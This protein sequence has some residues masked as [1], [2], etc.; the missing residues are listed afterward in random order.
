MNSRREQRV[1]LS[2]PY[3]TGTE[4]QRVAAAIESNWLAPLGPALA[5][6][7]RD[8]AKITGFQHVTAVSSGTA[9]LHLLLTALDLKP[10][11]DIW[12]P[13][14]TFMGGVSPI[15]FCGHRPVFFDVD[16]AN[17]TLSPALIADELD[18]S[19]KSGSLPRAIIA[20]DLFGHPFDIDRIVA[21]A[22]RYNVPVVGDSAE[23]LGVLCRGRHAG[24]GTRGAILSFNGNKIITTSGG[25]AVMTDDPALDSR[26]RYFATQTREPVAWYEHKEVGFN[27][28]L[29]NISAALGSAQLESLDYRVARRRDIFETYRA[30]LSDIDG[31]EWTQEAD[32]AFHTRWLSV[33]LVPESLGWKAVC[34][35]VESLEKLNIEARP[36]WKPMHLQPVFKTARTVGGDFSAALFSR[37]LCLPSGTGMTREEQDAVIEAVRASLK[38]LSA[39]KTA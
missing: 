10:D 30:R 19:A 11:G 38:A 29:S 25:G 1:F 27:Y 16:P 34:G 15:L 3:Q 26:I 24:R 23:G 32:W 6:F 4:R 18:R 31:V 22:D 14:L 33:M 39:H 36:V 37:G 5:E 20:T 8:L 7:E 13:S 21:A 17:L 35:L 12:V 28:R 9:A 2:P